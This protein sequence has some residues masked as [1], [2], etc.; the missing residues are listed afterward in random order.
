MNSLAASRLGRILLHTLAG[1][2]DGEW[3]C[4]LEGIV[5]EI[6]FK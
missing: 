3:R 5:R 2:C 4:H 6:L 1:A